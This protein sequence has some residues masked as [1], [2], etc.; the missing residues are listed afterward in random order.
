MSQDNEIVPFAKTNYRGQ[1]R[2]FGIRVDDRRRHIYVIGKTG[3]GKTTLLENM[4]IADIQGGRGLAIVDPHGQ[5]AD[6]ML[7]FVPPQRI[8]DVIYFNPADYDYPIAF[9]I[10]ERVEPHYKHLIADGLVGVFKKI[11]ADSWG[12]RLEYILRNAILALLDYPS[13]TLLGVTRILVDKEYRRKVV[14]KIQDPV[15]RSFWVNEYANYSENFRNEAISPIQNKVGQFLS[16]SLIR[17]IIGQPQS[18]INIRDVMDHGKILLMNI[19]KGKVGEENSALL[20]AMMI[21]KIQLAAMSRADIPEE[22]RHDFYLYIDEFQ[23][24]ST[25]SF[26]NILSEARKYRLNLIMAHQYI[27][28]MEEKVRDAVFGNVGTIICFRVGAMDAEFLEPEFQPVFTQLDLVNLTKFEIYLKLMIDGVASDAFSAMTLPPIE[29]EAPKYPEAREKITRISRERYATPRAVVEEKINRWSGMEEGGKNGGGAQGGT[30]VREGARSWPQQQKQ[31][32]QHPQEEHFKRIDART[33]AP[34]KPAWDNFSRHFPPQREVEPVA[35]RVPPP[36]SLSEALKQR[37]QS[38][39]ASDSRLDSGVKESHFST[40]R[41]D[42]FSRRIK[43]PSVLNDNDHRLKSAGFSNGVK[44]E[45][46]RPDFK[47]VDEDET[48]KL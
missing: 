28:Q 24:F 36:I 5:F 45:N 47:R 22:E 37:P 18:S 43:P 19:A 38:F 39:S 20:G 23:N 17:N 27:T 11:W 46:R 33:A 41:A 30:Q 1:E 48:I 9:N 15:V 44:K 21:T 7:D 13:S 42:S 29:K 14:Q 10:F 3:M 16:S 40:V 6:K 8:N 2:K 31:Q 35:K 32:Q 25:D 26:A 4:A 12:P 34:S